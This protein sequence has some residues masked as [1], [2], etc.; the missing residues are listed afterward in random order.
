MDGV[1]SMWNNL[2]PFGRIYRK[3]SKKKR[4]KERQ[5]LESL[6]EKE[7]KTLEISRDEN[8]QYQG[9]ILQRLFLARSREN[10]FKEAV[11]AR[12]E[13][14]KGK[15]R[16]SAEEWEFMQNHPCI[17]RFAVQDGNFLIESKLIVITFEGWQYKIGKFLINI[18][19]R[20]GKI[21]IYNIQNS[22]Q[23][24]YGHPH[25]KQGELKLAGGQRVALGKLLGRRRFGQVIEMVLQFL[26]SYDCKTA[27]YPIQNW[28][29]R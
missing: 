19:T 23:H 16:Q 8:I 11:Q 4:Q 26:Q 22:C 2:M 9:Q 20:E 27:F 21:M 28:Q 1:R 6:I 12:E 15:K 17:N 14:L 25:I 7:I 29:R 5:L 10:E 24:G 13:Y 18:L 3:I